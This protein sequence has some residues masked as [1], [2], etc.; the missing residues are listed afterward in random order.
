VKID[1][2][3]YEVIR[4]RLWSLNEE[5]GMTIARISGSPIVALAHDF[6]P[7]LHAADGE[8][9][10]SG[11]YIQALNAGAPNAIRWIYSEYGLD[12]IRPGDMFLTN[13]PWVGVS[14]QIDVSI[15]APV[16]VGTKLIAWVT[17]AV[18]Q[19][20]VGGPVPGSFIP[21][22]RE[23]FEESPPIPPIRIVEE[24]TLRPDLERM[25]V[26]RSRLPDLLSLDL[27]AGIAGCD[28]AKVALHA[29]IEEFGLE[30]LTSVM[31]QIVD[32]AERAFVE[33][34]R[35][36]PD[37]TWRQ[38]YYLEPHDPARGTLRLTMT[39]TKAGDR[40]LFSNEGDPD[41]DAG[42]AM[43]EVGWKGSITAAVA[44]TLCFDQLFALGG[45]LRRID[46]DLAEGSLG[47]ATFP[48]AMSCA[49]MRITNVTSA[50]SQVVA[51][52][53]ACSPATRGHSVGAGGDAGMPVLLIAGT[54]ERG[55]PYGTALTDHIAAAIAPSPDRDG[56]DTGG[57]AW[58]PRAA[59][60]NV[61]DQELL[62]PILYLY[63]REAADSGGAGRSRGGNGGEFAFVPLNVERIDLAT[64]TSS[65]GT[66][67]PAA[68]GL[69][70]GL[71]GSTTRYTLVRDSGAVGRLSE[72][73]IATKLDDL[74][75][76]LGDIPGRSV[77]LVQYADDVVEE[78][79]C[80]T[81]GY[82]DPLLRDARRV[83][84]DVVAGKVSGASAA[85]A[86]GVVLRN[87]GS[88]DDDATEE[89]RERIRAERH[90]GVEPPVASH[91]QGVAQQEVLRVADILAVVKTVAGHAFACV[92]CGYLLCSTERNY[93]DGCNTRRR[94][95]Q[96][97]DP[98]AAPLASTPPTEEVG[99][100]E[101]YCPGCST[102]LACDIVLGGRRPASDLELVLT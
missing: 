91:D 20:D 77:G 7:C 84:A 79:W 53:L 63:R 40:L 98:R 2:I 56:V 100:F 64:I 93:R 42:Q 18:H 46:Y 49:N 73:V 19:Y 14:H 24:G 67:M 38:E 101:S 54:D 89:C 59:I 33:R 16:H 5:H 27:R 52:M 76:S 11:P 102:R 13:D 41:Q 96:E 69:F 23:I 31:E 36:I 95:L 85:A 10:F 68:E 71:P 3:T 9:I 32:N 61:E 65:A 4:H 30:A 92:H 43:T 90:S 6:N 26:R 39:L 74:L 78:R 8:L 66:V 57:I 25:Y 51:K 75:G 28:V 97:A 47:A 81:G 45:A 88:P 60:P 48:A 99:L 70:G 87:D 22:A 86:Y 15:L 17:N 29:A 44:S 34:L 50:A 80:G 55:R 37:G 21:Q 1:P 12:F 94:P 35:G 82:G 72:R 83:A 62:F 58:D